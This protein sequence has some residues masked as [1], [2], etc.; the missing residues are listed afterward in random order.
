MS[1]KIPVDRVSD[2]RLGRDPALDAWLDHFLTEN[3][4]SYLLN[5]TLVATPEQLRFMVALEENQ[6]YLPCSDAIFKLL[7]DDDFPDE[8]KSSYRN[9]WTFVETLARESSVENY[10][11]ERVLTFLNHRFRLAEDEHILIPPRLLKRLLS[12]VL[13]QC[14]NPDPYSGIRRTAD[15]AAAD[16]LADGRVRQVVQRLPPGLAQDK[17]LSDLRWSLDKL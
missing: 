17:A 4:L 10:V 7:L 2:I 8:L 6:V 1:P 5:P 3:N 9:V 11:R 14:G 13:S 15:R 12:V 16:F